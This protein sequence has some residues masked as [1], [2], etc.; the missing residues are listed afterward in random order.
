MASCK[1]W[2]ELV[3][4]IQGRLTDTTSTRGVKREMSKIQPLPRTLSALMRVFSILVQP[5][6]VPFELIWGLL[7]L[8]ITVGNSTAL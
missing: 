7:F 8:N 2:H 6:K 1:D 3:S 4:E 5:L